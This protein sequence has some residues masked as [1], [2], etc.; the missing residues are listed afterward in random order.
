MSKNLNN[1]WSLLTPKQKKFFYFFIL[2][3]F[4]SSF[5]EVLSL[6]TIIPVLGSILDPS[7][8]QKLF[9]YDKLI[10]LLGNIDKNLFTIYSI[11]FLVIVF[12]LKNLFLSFL[13]WFHLYFINT[14]RIS[15]SKKLYNLYLNLPFTFHLK[16]NSTILFRN[17]D[18]EILNVS[19]TVFKIITLIVEI[20]VF[21]SIITF[22]FY[23]NFKVTLISLIFIVLIGSIFYFV[24]RS[25]LIDWGKKRQFHSGKF[26]QH[27][28]HGLNSIKD[29]KM[30]DRQNSFLNLFYKNQE[31]AV[32]YARLETVTTSLTRYLLEFISILGLGI[33]IVLM[34]L[35]NKNNTEIIITISL[36][37]AAIYR[38]A[39]S[40]NKI[41]TSLS[42]L[43]FLSISVTT[44][45]N[46]FE[47][48]KK[49]NFGQLI[50][51]KK[52]RFLHDLKFKNLNYKYPGT[53]KYIL[54]D[55]Q[56]ALKKNSI[57]GLYGKSG[58]GKTTLINIIC[59]LL[60][61]E[62][63]DLILDGK[64]FDLNKDK[65]RLDIGYISQ[66]TTLIDDSVEKNIAFGIPEQEIDKEMLKRCVKISRVDNF[67]DALPNGLK[68][69]V[70]ERGTRLSGGQ[71]QRIGIA[72][73]LYNNPE[74]LIIDE[75]TN[76]LDNKTEL[77]ILNDI[78]SLKNF[79]TIIII[80]HDMNI[81]K[82]YSDYCFE[83]N[84]NK[85][86]EIKLNEKN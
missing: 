6:G 11:I 48:I 4:I 78:S 15:L 81:I 76:S 10:N 14:I 44:I 30:L 66:S 33:F 25:K 24:M 77:E 1:I 5:L 60:L 70:G 53:S 9:F 46:E 73:A 65:C 72:R 61:P 80:S 85:I 19:Q 74:I 38:L 52:H 55:A 21:F 16:N 7:M 37:G 18:Y 17:I 23:Y 83:L 32:R 39:P 28:F 40:A 62:K 8:F 84:D 63:G 59:N 54:K 71:Q 64:K 27:L 82:S 49:E 56:F 35:M 51:L 69:K 75:G 50:N 31:L 13:T 3:S 68:T 86:I 67:L 26:L 45:K 2:L 57:V 79:L 36:L 47:R 41:I 58:S 20:L 29:V 42:S 12:L 34:T 43:Q 22:L